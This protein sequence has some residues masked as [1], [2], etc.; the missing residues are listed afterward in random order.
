[1]QDP[2]CRTHRVELG[3]ASAAATHG[4]VRADSRVKARSISVA[5]DQILFY[6]RQFS[7]Q[8]PMSRNRNSLALPGIL[9]RKYSFIAIFP[10]FY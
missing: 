1:M 7:R 2:T 4:E 5:C 3:P 6:H 10:N 9:T 8:L